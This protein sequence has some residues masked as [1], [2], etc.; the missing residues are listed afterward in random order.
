MEGTVARSGATHLVSILDAGTPL[1]R[2]AGVHPSRHLHLEF[3][4]VAEPFPGMRLPS[5][6]DME[7]LIGFVRDWDA[8]RPLVIHC[9]AGISRSTASAFVALCALDAARDESSIAQVLRTRSPSAFPNPLMVR[10][11]DGLLGRS[12]RMSAAV[13]AMSPPLPAFESE[14]FAL[15]IRD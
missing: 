2:P 11:A 14:P 4:D 13:A 1:V 3:H 7:R 12:G 10:L 8:E 6:N 5:A 9:F 15:S